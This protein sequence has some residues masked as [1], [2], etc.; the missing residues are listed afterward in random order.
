[1]APLA[2]HLSTY[3]VFEENRKVGT[4]CHEKQCTQVP[5]ARIFGGRTSAAGI[6]CNS[7]V[8]KSLRDVERRRGKECVLQAQNS[9]TLQGRGDRK[10]PIYGV[11]EYATS[12]NHNQPAPLP[13]AVAS[14]I[15]QDV[16][17]LSRW[18]IVG[19]NAIGSSAERIWGDVPISAVH[20]DEEGVHFSFDCPAE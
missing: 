3:K 16:K 8:E 5:L 18:N 1:M 6:V 2:V 14:G 17:P 4:L 9:R 13:R 20:Q 10:T 11:A 7:L 19:F 15:M 12:V